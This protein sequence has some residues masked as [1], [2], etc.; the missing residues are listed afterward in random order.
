MPAAA[1]RKAH[2][3]VVL[4]KHKCPKLQAKDALSTSAQPTKTTRHENLT[5]SDWLTVFAYVDAH[6]DESQNSIV[7]GF[8]E[9]PEGALVFSQVA[10]S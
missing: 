10:L 4:Y 3:V 8:A 2:T 1:T 5:L 7:A 6:P 9:R